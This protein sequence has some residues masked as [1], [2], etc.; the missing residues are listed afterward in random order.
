MI[1]AYQRPE[2]PLHEKV[3]NDG[4]VSG[5]YKNLYIK[6]SLCMMDGVSGDYTNLYMKRWL[7]MDGLAA[8]TQTFT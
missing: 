2:K 8:T 5:D 4:W 7:M 3:A 1:V 6:R